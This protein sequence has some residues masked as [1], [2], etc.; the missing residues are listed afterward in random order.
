MQRLT[1]W[2]ALVGMAFV[3]A[4]FFGPAV[5]LAAGYLPA[6]AGLNPAISL[7]F[8]ATALV[9]VAYLLGRPLPTTD[10]G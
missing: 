8:G 1:L 5:A 2:L 3:W 4:S 10:R 7:L 6:A 9:A